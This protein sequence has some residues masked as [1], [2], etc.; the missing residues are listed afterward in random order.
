[1]TRFAS[2]RS[3]VA[4]L[5][6]GLLLVVGCDSTGPSDNASGASPV[7]VT[8]ALD[9]NLTF[10]A[11]DAS[12]GVLWI[13][14]F[15]DGQRATG[16]SGSA[17]ATNGQVTVDLPNVD[18]LSTTGGDFITYELGVRP[19]GNFSDFSVTL[20]NDGNAVATVT[21]PDPDKEWV[22]RVQAP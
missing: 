11:G 1:M 22:I 8:H 5:I 14:D 4:L 17:E 20:R 3:V 6:A 18:S 21:G 12:G 16:A 2:S 9:G 15:D 19:R 13:V 10:D 7:E